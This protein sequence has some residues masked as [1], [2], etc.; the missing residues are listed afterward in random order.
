[1]Y[2][3]ISHKKTIESLISCQCFC[4]DFYLFQTFISSYRITTIKGGTGFYAKKYS[5]AE[6]V[7]WDDNRKLKEEDKTM[8]RKIIGIF[9]CMLMIVTALS[10]AGAMNV[11][12]AWSVKENSYFKPSESLIT[13]QIVAKV[14][15]IDDPDNLLGGVI[16]INDIITGK[17]VYDSKTPDS[18]PDDP[19]EGSYVQNSSSCGFEVNAGG[20]VFKSDS[21]DLVFFINILNDWNINPQ[22]I[23]VVWS[24][25]NLPLS[26][27]MNVGGIAM[28][29]TDGTCTALSSDSLP[30]TAPVLAD[31]P[32]Q[33]FTLY[34]GDPSDPSKN[35]RIEA[36]LTSILKIETKFVFGRYTNLVEESG[37]I[38]VEAVN[39]RLILFNPFQFIHYNA[40]EQVTF[41]KD[42]SKVMILPQFIIGILK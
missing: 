23:Y 31:W 5:E 30:I 18:E 9:V 28:Q 26:N 14:N 4:L 42:T 8:K 35:Y 10:A 2:N 41:A 17:Y 7:L 21:S 29:L 1:M 24:Q 13:I 19:T 38:T 40:G 20:F 16:H 37:F 27:G 25:K 11:Q 22:D 12:T 36:E 6:T 33:S 3:L 39:L 34:G 32:S 15:Y